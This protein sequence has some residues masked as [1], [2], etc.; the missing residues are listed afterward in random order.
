M[1]EEMKEL[2]EFILGR[3][4]E[5]IST[6]KNLSAKLDMMILKAKV[7]TAVAEDGVKWDEVAYRFVG[8]SSC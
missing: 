8:N 1:E 5:R 7:S 3:I 4:E 2:Q 6:E